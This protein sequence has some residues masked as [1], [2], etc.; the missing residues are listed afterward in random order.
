[1]LHIL[2]GFKIARYFICTYHLSSTV[3]TSVSQSQLSSLATGAGEDAV[4]LDIAAKFVQDIIDRAR[5]EAATK[6]NQETLVTLG[7]WQSWVNCQ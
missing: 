4:V 6:L 1:M 2:L 7:W 5:T 3:S